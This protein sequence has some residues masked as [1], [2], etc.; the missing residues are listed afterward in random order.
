[1]SDEFINLCMNNELDKA[2]DY[3]QNNKDIDINKIIYDTN[4]SDVQGPYSLFECMCIVNN[5]EFIKWFI[6]LGTTDE[7]YNNGFISACHYNHFDLVQY[8]YDEKNDIKLNFEASFLVCCYLGNFE[9]LKWLYYNKSE[10]NNID[11]HVQD[12]SPFIYSICEGHFEVAKW[13]YYMS[14]TE[15]KIINI[16]ID[17]NSPFIYACYYGSLDICKWL[18]L[19]SNNTIDKHMDND[20]P[21]RNAEISCNQELIEWLKK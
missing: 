6:E 5:I 18:Y 15:N 16:H 9:I 11:I 4:T 10:E 21:L 19:I 2:K 8:L 1:M 13:I 14:I 12:E 3:Y 17:D 20:R 7:N